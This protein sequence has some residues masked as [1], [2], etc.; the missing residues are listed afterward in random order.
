MPNVSIRR[1]IPDM[2]GFL[3]SVGTVIL[4]PTHEDA[5]MALPLVALEAH[6]L[7]ARVIMRKLAV[8][9]E[10]FSCGLAEPFETTEELISLCS[11]Q[12]AGKPAQTCAKPLSAFV[13]WIADTLI[14]N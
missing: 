1:T 11:K 8:F 7:G 2:A 3:A 5:T 12:A 10:L 9:D 4:P 13:S 14:D 6:H